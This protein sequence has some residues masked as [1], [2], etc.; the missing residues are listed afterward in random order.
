MPEVKFAPEEAIKKA[1]KVLDVT[2]Q[3]NV[4]STS[5]IWSCP[6]GKT[7]AVPSCMVK[8]CRFVGKNYCP[9]IRRSRK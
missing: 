1:Q 5:P 6:E 8:F 2:H 4:S 7:E 3:T 9:L